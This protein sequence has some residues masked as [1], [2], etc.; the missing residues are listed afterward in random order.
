MDKAHLWAATEAQIVNAIDKVRQDQFVHDDFVVDTLKPTIGIARDYVQE[1]EHY[2]PGTP[3]LRNIHQE[4][5]EA[6]RAHYF[7]LAALVDAADKKDYIQL[8][9]ANNDLQEAQRSVADALADLARL[10]REAGIMQ[11]ALPS[12]QPLTPSSEG[13]EVSPS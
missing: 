1:L 12:E 3:P 9:K 10:L 7:A 4:Y 6:W 5:I 13:F 8:A 11:K 2:Q